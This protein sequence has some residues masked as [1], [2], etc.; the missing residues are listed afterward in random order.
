MNSNCHDPVAD[1]EKQRQ[2]RICQY[3]NIPNMKFMV[4]EEIN[5]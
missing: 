4:Q 5:K 3:S 2:A 1:L